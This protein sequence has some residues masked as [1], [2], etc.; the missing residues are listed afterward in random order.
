[1]Q[2]TDDCAYNCSKSGSSSSGRSYELVIV[3]LDDT[4]NGAA[5]HG[6]LSKTDLHPNAVSKIYR[7]LRTTL[8]TAVDDCVLPTNPARIRGASKALGRVAAV[9]LGRRGRA[10]QRYRGI[11]EAI[12]RRMPKQ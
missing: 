9:H 2:V 4:R 5:W 8:T 6:R 1:M 11:A 7:L 12:A 10:C 3:R